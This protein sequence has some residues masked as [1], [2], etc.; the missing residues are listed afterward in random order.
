MAFLHPGD[1]SRSDW[2]F[3]L[4][5]LGGLFLGMVVVGVFLIYYVANKWKR[6]QAEEK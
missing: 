5:F 4:L 6:R 3:L 1:L 2:L